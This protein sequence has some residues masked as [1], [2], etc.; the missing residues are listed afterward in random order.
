MKDEKIETLTE[1]LNTTQED[2]YIELLK[3]RDELLQRISSIEIDVNWKE[4]YE[5]LQKKYTDQSHQELDEQKM[6]NEN[7]QMTLLKL[8][9]DYTQLNSQLID[10]SAF[11]SELKTKLEEDF[12]QSSAE[13]QSEFEKQLAEKDNDIL[14]LKDSLSSINEQTQQTINTLQLAHA[15]DRQLL[16]EKNKEVCD[17]N[18]FNHSHV[19]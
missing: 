2:K 1:Q 17:G 5:E 9:Q 6:I 4:Q 15:E 8:Q 13:K 7:L 16:D 18:Q 12:A 19:K 11:E 3:E 14:Q 10:R